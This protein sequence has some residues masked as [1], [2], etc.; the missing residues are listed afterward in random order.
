MMLSI[1]PEACDFTAPDRRN[2]RKIGGFFHRLDL[3]AGPGCGGVFPL[4]NLMRGA[5]YL[6]R[7]SAQRFLFAFHP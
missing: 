4:Y 2:G 3:A 1:F 6:C 5:G 7:V